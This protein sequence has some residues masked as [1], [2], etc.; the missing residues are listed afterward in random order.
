MMEVVSLSWRPGRTVEVEVDVD[1]T[2][3]VE[4]W[5]ENP[6]R[7]RRVVVDEVTLPTL[8]L[9]ATVGFSSRASRVVERVV[10][11]TAGCDVSRVA[12][13]RRSTAL[14]LSPLAALGA[15]PISPSAARRRVPGLPAWVVEIPVAAG[16]LSAAAERVEVDP[17]ADA[18]R[19]I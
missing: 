19:F 6:G 12:K 7:G 9:T 18:A 1:A 17:S 2:E 8:R 10:R 11:R 13:G 14:P 15:V 16:L 4:P 5:R 3:V